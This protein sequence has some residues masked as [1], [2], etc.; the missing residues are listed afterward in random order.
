[1][2]QI[3]IVIPD[4]LEEAFRD[5]A[6]RESL[7]MSQLGFF[8][9]QLGFFAYVEGLNK[10]GV[11]KKLSVRIQRENVESVAEV[12]EAETQING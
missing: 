11:Y 3:T 12:E 1:M 10:Y 8:C 5:V 7:K 4:S 2:A 9:L 6:G